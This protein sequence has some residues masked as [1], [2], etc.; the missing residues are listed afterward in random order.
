MPK[1]TFAPSSLD[2]RRAYATASIVLLA[3]VKLQHGDDQITRISQFRRFKQ[4]IN[5]AKRS[6]SVARL[7]SVIIWMRFE[8][9]Y[10]RLDRNVWERV[11][12]STE[13]QRVF[14]HE[15]CSNFLFSS[16]AFALKD[17]S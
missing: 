11:P 17:S 4:F 5:Y 2:N 1:N 7:G 14:V 8:F 3:P 12:R 13:N 9:R 10:S 15:S 6:V 16:S